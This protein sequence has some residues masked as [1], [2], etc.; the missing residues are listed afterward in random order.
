MSS[1]RTICSQYVTLHNTWHYYAKLHSSLIHILL[2]FRFRFG[3]AFGRVEAIVMEWIIS[4]M[5]INNSLIL[6]LQ[7]KITI[8]SLALFFLCTTLSQICS[9]GILVLRSFL[10][11][12]NV[13]LIPSLFNCSCITPPQTSGILIKLKSQP[14]SRHFTMSFFKRMPVNSGISL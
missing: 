1:N 5:I 4:D 12:Y 2:K 9:Y 14:S 3:K 6:L 13:N 7:N 10:R 8:H 11:L